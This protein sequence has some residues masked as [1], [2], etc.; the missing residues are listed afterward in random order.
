M[1]LADLFK[2]KKAKPSPGKDDG[3]PDVSADAAD[4]AAA[5]SPRS[6]AEEKE[7]RARETGT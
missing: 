2:S 3:L 7:F 5:A 4:A 6:K 1:G